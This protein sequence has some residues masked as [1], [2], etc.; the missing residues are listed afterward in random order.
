MEF[1]TSEIFNLRQQILLFFHYFFKRH[2]FGS[3][4]PRNVIEKMLFL[5]S[6]NA[7]F[8]D[9]GSDHAGHSYSNY[10]ENLNKLH[11]GLYAFEVDFHIFV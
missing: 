1:K 3:K 9:S 4:S 6:I 8:K 11:Q 7:L 10:V 5:T 2:N